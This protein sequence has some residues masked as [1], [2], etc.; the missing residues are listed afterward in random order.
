MTVFPESVCNNDEVYT[1][2]DKQK[3]VDQIYKTGYYR[4]NS[5]NQKPIYSIKNG[6]SFDPDTTCTGGTEFLNGS[7]PFIGKVI[8]NEADSNEDNFSNEYELFKYGF[9]GNSIECTAPFPK[10]MND[11]YILRLRIALYSSN[12][13]TV[14]FNGEGDS[15]VT[16]FKNLDYS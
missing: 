4:S 11:N 12:S 3:F 14:K 5:I 7:P 8:K 9:S 15:N 6:I 10:I 2:A 16:S 1:R 13:I